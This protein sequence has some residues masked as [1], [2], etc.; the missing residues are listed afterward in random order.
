[1]PRCI[2]RWSCIRVADA[3]DKVVTKQAGEEDLRTPGLLLY[4]ID[5]L[6][7]REHHEL[8]KGWPANEY[9]RVLRWA[10]WPR[11][12]MRE[13][14]LIQIEAKDHGVSSIRRQGCDSHAD[15]GSAPRTA[16]NTFAKATEG[17]RHRFVEN[18][19]S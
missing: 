10:F 19:W 11:G 12:F 2:F 4:A 7:V 13:P 17:E 9:W 5:E 8:P 1:M 6:G 15:V 3:I 16:E 18:T 14:G